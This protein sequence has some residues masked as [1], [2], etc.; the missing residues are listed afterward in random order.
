MTE[1]ACAAAMGW[2]EV[3]FKL[4][5]LLLMASVAL[6]GMLL[7]FLTEKRESHD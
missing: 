5:G 6:G 3:I 4:G 1:A 7:L 2:P